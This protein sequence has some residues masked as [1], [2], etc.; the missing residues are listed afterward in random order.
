MFVDTSK[1][2]QE[3]EQLKEI[4]KII[5]GIRMLLLV[6]EGKRKEQDKEMAYF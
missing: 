6:E 5:S 4:N 1:Q 2:E 3:E